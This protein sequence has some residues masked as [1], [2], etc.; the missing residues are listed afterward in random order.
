VPT[1]RG[2]EETTLRALTA[3][4]SLLSECA[5]NSAALSFYAGILCTT[6]M[7]HIA[8]RAR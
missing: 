3:G 2:I 4:R 8:T 7:Q 6:L 1:T 5:V